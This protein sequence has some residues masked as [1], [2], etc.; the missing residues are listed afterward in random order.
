M[1][2]G[3]GLKDMTKDEN[4]VYIKHQMDLMKLP[5]MDLRLAQPNEIEERCIKFFEIC[6]ENGQKPSIASMALSLNCARNTLVDYIKGNR[7]IPN[8]NRAILVKYYT[9]MNGL[10][11][12]YVQDNKI[13][14]VVA[15]FLMKNNY[16]YR[17]TEQDIE[18]DNKIQ[19]ESIENLIAESNLLLG[20]IEEI[21]STEIQN[22]NSALLVDDKGDE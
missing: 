15:N 21:K 5:P 19:Q 16:G 6:V 1:A 18:I 14:P 11:E 2:F 10:T 17:D 12:A 3:A 4:E 20:E 8:D 7:A 13:N 22:N 9:V